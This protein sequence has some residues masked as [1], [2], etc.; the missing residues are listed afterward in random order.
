MIGGCTTLPKGYE[1]NKGL[2]VELSERLKDIDAEYNVIIDY[3]DVTRVSLVP[4]TPEDETKTFFVSIN[5]YPELNGPLT[6]AMAG[7]QFVKTYELQKQR[8]LDIVA[9]AIKDNL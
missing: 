3:K 9:Q 2:A 4:F 1:G 8:D 7:N 6:P 5:S